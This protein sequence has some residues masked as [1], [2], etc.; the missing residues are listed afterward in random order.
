[1]SNAK[2]NISSPANK[3]NPDLLLKLEGIWSM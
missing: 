1:L 3:A 2:P